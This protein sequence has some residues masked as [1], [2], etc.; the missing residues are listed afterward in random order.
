MRRILVGGWGIFGVLMVLTCM[1][2]GSVCA[3]DPI[4]YD[5]D[6][7][8]GWNF[9]SLPVE[10]VTVVSAQEL[11]AYVNTS[12]GQATT[13]SR[14]EK[15]GWQTLVIL[16]GVEYGS[17][18]KLKPF[19]AYFLLNYLPAKIEITGL[20]VEAAKINLLPGWNAI[21]LMPGK[22]INARDVLKD[23]N[24]QKNE[25][26]TEIDLWYSGNWTPFV[27]REYDQS[28]IQEYGEAFRLSPNSGYMLKMNQDGTLQ[29]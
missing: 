24:R 23:I 1:T 2:S 13:V 9:I 16:G 11:I 28:N 5:Y 12:G 7:V 17:D 19:E 3:A 14:W 15:D 6:L 29:W 20:P 27:Y 10:P 22:M 18:F 8:D 25:A 4:T 21:G 26:A